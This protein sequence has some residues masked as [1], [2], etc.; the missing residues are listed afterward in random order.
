VTGKYESLGDHLRAC[1]ADGDRQVELTFGKIDRLVDGLP[2]SA[3]RARTWWGNGSQSQAL[4]W[5]GA[6][7]HVHSVDL[8][9]QR[10]V[11]VTGKVGG[12]YAARGRVPAAPR[13]TRHAVGLTTDHVE[14][15]ALDTAEVS[16]RFVWLDAG[17]VTLDRGGKPAFPDLPHVP[18]MYRLTL[19]G[20]PGQVRTRVYLGESDNLRRRL[21][22]NYRSPGHGQQT[23]LR[24]NA[25]LREHLAAGGEGA[26]AVATE[27][28]VTLPEHG[29]RPL[30]LTRKAGRLLAEN[31]AL[32]T[33]QINDDADIENL[34]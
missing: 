32:V 25:L 11:F 20:R 16:V 2:P 14:L 18:G 10:V 9:G 31:A 26:L 27:A 34:G 33:A 17:T 15:A 28:T 7:W 13:P 19:T 8:P 23:S 24:V 30:D 22:G 6:G 3:R 21:A 29:S 4:A 5:R 1:A 12:S